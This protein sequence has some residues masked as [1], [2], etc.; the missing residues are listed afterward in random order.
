M[1]FQNYSA[2]AGSP[3]QGV[4]TIFVNRT[5]F[6]GFND[7]IGQSI[8]ALVEECRVQECPDFDTAMTGNTTAVQYA[9]EEKVGY[10]FIGGLVIVVLAIIIYY[11]RR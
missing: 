9:E 2:Q 3:P 4:P 6:V 11:F 1:L 8:M 7:A 5:A 10:F